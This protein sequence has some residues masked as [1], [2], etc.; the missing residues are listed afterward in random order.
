MLLS[1]QIN[2]RIIEWR[3]ERNGANGKAYS[4]IMKLCRKCL[5]GYKGCPREMVWSHSKFE[6]D[7]LTIIDWFP[8]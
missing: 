6:P 5:S 8:G 1:I 4:Q 7:S 2:Q 3:G